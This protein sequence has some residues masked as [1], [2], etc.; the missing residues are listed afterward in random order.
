MACGL[1][2]APCSGEGSRYRTARREASPGQAPGRFASTPLPRLLLCTARHAHTATQQRSAPPPTPTVTPTITL[3]VR[4]RRAPAVAAPTA[5]AAGGLGGGGAAGRL[6]ATRTPG[7]PA[8]TRAAERSVG[9]SGEESADRSAPWAAAAGEVTVADRAMDAT[10]GATACGDR[11]A[12]QVSGLGCQRSACTRAC[13]HLAACNSLFS[14]RTVTEAV[15]RPE[16]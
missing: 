7:R 3:S 10:G 2:A 5:T 9:R 16:A 1:R 12:G 15:G 13:G 6:A 14:L 11:R 8:K 4:E